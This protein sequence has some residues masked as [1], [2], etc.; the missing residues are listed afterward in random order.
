MNQTLSS[1][2]IAFVADHKDAGLV[3]FAEVSLRHDH[4][5]G[6]SITPVPYLEGW[7]VEQRFRRQGIGRSLITTAEMWAVDHGFAEFASD[8][9][10]DDHTSIAIHKILGFREVDR[11]V[12]FIKKIG[13]QRGKAE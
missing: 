10:I 3:G 6:A 12:H 7:F 4:V 13:I 1:D 11:T 9:E 2:G 5:N 8:A